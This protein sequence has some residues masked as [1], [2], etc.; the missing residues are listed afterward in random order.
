MSEESTT[1]D[2]VELTREVYKVATRQDLDALIAF[3]TPDAVWDLSHTGI[4]IF[5]GVPAIAAFF[6]DWWATWE[7]HH[8]EVQEV[9]VLDHGVV[10]AVVREDGQLVGSDV[11]V[12]QRGGWV[13]VWVGS[14]IGSVTAYLDIDEGRAAA[15]RLAE[16]RG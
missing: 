13:S 11:Y 1:P 15:E 5:E 4:G 14:L 10:F 12:E 2:L 7:D 3:F 9:V 6:Q 8:H 16:S